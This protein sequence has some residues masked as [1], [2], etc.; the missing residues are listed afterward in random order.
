MGEPKKAEPSGKNSRRTSPRDEAK[1]QKE[2]ISSLS[3]A[4]ENPHLGIPNWAPF[5][6][7]ILQRNKVQEAED[8][9]G[10]THQEEFAFVPKKEGFAGGISI[11]F[12]NLSAQPRPCQSNRILIRC[13]NMTRIVLNLIIHS[14]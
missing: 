1:E 12:P 13:R 9:D 4:S 5:P 10:K 3:P 11:C 7:L 6:C 8:S 14:L 2:T